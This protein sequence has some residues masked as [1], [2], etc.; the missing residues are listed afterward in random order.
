MTK[1][2][3]YFIVSAFLFLLI[4][5][6]HL[7]RLVNSLDLKLGGYIIPAWVSLIIVVL[8]SFMAYRGFKLAKKKL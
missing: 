8:A 3:K 1:P 7:F 5:V 2:K 6:G 4:A